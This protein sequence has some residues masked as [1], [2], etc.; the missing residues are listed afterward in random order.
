MMSRLI[1][2]L[3]SLSSSHFFT[4]LKS[5]GGTREKLSK[6]NL[7]RHGCF[8]YDVHIMKSNQIVKFIHLLRVFISIQLLIKVLWGASV[9]GSVY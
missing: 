1:L 3:F 2:S 4:Q 5:H 8:K 6:Q 9:L 7:G